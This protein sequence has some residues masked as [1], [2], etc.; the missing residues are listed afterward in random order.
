M[1][2]NFI[3]IFLFFLLCSLLIQKPDNAK[4]LIQDLATSKEMVMDGAEYVKKTFDKEFT[5]VEE[6]EGETFFNDN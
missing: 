5:A 3:I 6:N 2:K 1:F 4:I